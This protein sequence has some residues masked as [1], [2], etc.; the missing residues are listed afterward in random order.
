MEN[1]KWSQRSRS[2]KITYAA[3]NSI[4]FLTIFAA[5]YFVMAFRETAANSHKKSL[6]NYDMQKAK[7]EAQQ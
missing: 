1:K 6:E 5:I 3:M 2:E 7:T 4:L